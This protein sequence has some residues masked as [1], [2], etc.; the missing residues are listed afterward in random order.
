MNANA[1]VQG[2]IATNIKDSRLKR[3]HRALCQARP[4]K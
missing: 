4:M 3:S 1:A 2:D